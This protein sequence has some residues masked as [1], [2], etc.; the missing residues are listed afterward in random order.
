MK[1]KDYKVHPVAEMFPLIP[2]GTKDWGLLIDS[3][4]TSGQLEPCVVDGEI[5]LDGRNR[6]RACEKLKRQPVTVEWGAL[7]LNVNQA[8]WIAAK[9]LSRRHLTDDQKA[10]IAYEVD[11]WQAKQDAALA[12]ARTQFKKGQSGNPSGK[13]KEQAGAKSTQ[14]ARAPKTTERIAEKAGVSEHKVRQAAKVAKAVEAGALSAQVKEEVKAGTRKLSD[15]AKATQKQEKKKSLRERVQGKLNKL[16]QSFDSGER[17]KVKE[18][19]R[20]ILL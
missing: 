12:A 1:L 3:I 14:P 20:E 6:M 10:M 7:G 9:N 11:V 18:I 2:E 13:P 17:E 5:L 16:I 4:E 19:L 15:A 8:E